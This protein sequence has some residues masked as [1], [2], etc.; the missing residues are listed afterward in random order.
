MKWM[1]IRT[2]SLM[3]FACL[4]SGCVSPGRGLFPAPPGQTPRTIYVLQR[5][6]YTAGNSDLLDIFGFP[7]ELC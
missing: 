4:V 1:R 6:L 3:A 2:A 7:D 5:G